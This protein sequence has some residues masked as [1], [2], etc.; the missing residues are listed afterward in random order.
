MGRGKRWSW[1]APR[2]FGLR[3]VRRT[4]R[5]PAS[6]SAEQRQRRPVGAEE[7]KLRVG[8]WLQGRSLSVLPGDPLP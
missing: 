8:T 4:A 3:P 5:A 2:L 7:A 1:A 6:Y